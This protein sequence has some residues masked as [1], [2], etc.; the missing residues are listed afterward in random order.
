[1]GKLF[2]TEDIGDEES[3]ASTRK[4]DAGSEFDA[5]TAKAIF[6]TKDSVPSNVRG[7]T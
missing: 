2:D 7:F 4:I 3:C 5:K 6:S 1:M